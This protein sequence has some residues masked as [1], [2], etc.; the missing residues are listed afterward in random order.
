MLE[1]TQNRV[2]ENRKTLRSLAMKLA[3]ATAE[4]S[5]ATRHDIT[6][7]AADLA[8]AEVAHRYSRMALEEIT[9]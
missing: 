5:T 6:G 4:G 1:N 7:I 9:T 8:V 2:E 3:A